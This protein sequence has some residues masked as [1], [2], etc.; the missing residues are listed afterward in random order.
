[1]NASL[2]LQPEIGVT[3]TAEP[4]ARLLLGDLLAER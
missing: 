2:I 3:L 4:M 1:L